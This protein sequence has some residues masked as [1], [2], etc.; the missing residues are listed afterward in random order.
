MEIQFPKENILYED[1]SI[2]VINKPAGFL[3]IQDGYDKS[4]PYLSNILE[5]EFGSLWIIHR[6]DRDTS[7][8][9]I[10][11]RTEEAHRY[12]NTEFRNRRVEKKYHALV[13]GLPIWD[14]FIASFPLLKDGDRK[15]RTTINYKKGKKA[16]TQ[17]H[18]LEKYNGF[19]L[20]EACPKTGYT[21]QIR[22]HLAYVGYPIV[23]DCLY[24]KSKLITHNEFRLD[25]QFS[26]IS[27]KRLGLHS[28]S[29]TFM[30]PISFKE[31]TFFAP[32]PA[33]F[34]D[35]INALR[36]FSVIT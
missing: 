16:S 14:D 28:R 24:S 11:A 6:L 1:E 18:L 35:A 7:G 25:R 2:L 10:L 17:F 26:I 33:D 12:L 23:F 4:L 8:V 20:I 36:N 13:I 5:P 32:Y 9:L 34:S 30:H 22:T 31:V 21:H 27:L 29:I 3:S 15:H 19:S